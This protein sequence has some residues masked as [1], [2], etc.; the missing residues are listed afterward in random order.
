MNNFRE[1]DTAI[2]AG[3]N[4]IC[5]KVLAYDPATDMRF[6]KLA[7]KSLKIACL[8]PE[9]N[10]YCHFTSEGPEFSLYTDDTANKPNATISGSGRDIFF[11]IFKS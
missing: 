9:I 10:L 7:G 8:Q 6:K 5:Q 3:L 1:V 2:T 11:F 4:K